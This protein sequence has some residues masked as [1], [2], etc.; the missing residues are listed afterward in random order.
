MIDFI[1]ESS[2]YQY[3]LIIEELSKI[4]KELTE[5]EVE[6]IFVN[7]KQMQKINLDNRNINK[8]TDVLSFPIDFKGQPLIGT[9]VVSLDMAKSASEEFSHSTEDEIKLL[10]IHGLLHLLGFDHEVDNGKM[11][12]KE[13]EI[14][15]KLNLPDSLILRNDG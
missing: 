12:E 7:N 10:F 5:D 8:P 1:N 6:L 2:D 3:D 13:I 9:I 4:K 15:K 14:I 11:R